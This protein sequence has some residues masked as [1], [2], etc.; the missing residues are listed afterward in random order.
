MNDKVKKTLEQ[1]ESLQKAL[2]GYVGHLEGHAQAMASN[3]VAASAAAEVAQSFGKRS[4][5]IATEILR[6][7]AKAKP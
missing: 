4:A 6:A 5:E 7:H 2:E 1:F 3:H